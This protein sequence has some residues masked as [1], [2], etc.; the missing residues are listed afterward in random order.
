MW[1]DGYLRFLII[2]DM[3]RDMLHLEHGPKSHPIRQD[4]LTRAGFLYTG[5]GDKVTCPWCKISLIE[6]ET[7]D[8][9]MD[10][11]KRHAPT[12]EFVKMIMPKNSFFSPTS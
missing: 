9:P 11:H 6:W 1:E 8:I 10:E 7:Y 12:C 5:E 3:M 4:A 2:L